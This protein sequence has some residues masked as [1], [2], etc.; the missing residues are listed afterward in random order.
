[1]SGFPK[2]LLYGLVIV[3][4]QIR[5]GTKQGK[6]SNF[7]NDPSVQTPL[8]NTSLEA[9]NITHFRCKSQKVLPPNKNV[10]IYGYTR[11]LYKIHSSGCMILS[12][13]GLNCFDPCNSAIKSL[14]CKVY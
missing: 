2:C 5:S 8:Y 10:L 11:H 12:D 13:C 1:M 3:M 14:W 9:L 6:K 7:L 4:T